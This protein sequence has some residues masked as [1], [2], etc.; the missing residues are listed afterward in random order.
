MSPDP[1]PAALRW[2]AAASAGTC[3]ALV[4]LPFE[5]PVLAIRLG[6]LLVTL[7]EALLGGAVAAA[8]VAAGLARR[9][10]P[11]CPD[12]RLAV[13][14]AA[15]V[16]VLL[17]STLAAP[18]GPLA[19]AKFTLRLA[20]GG[21]FAFAVVWLV[22]TRALAAGRAL[23]AY[24][25]GVGLAAVVGLLE[26][27]LA[28]DLDPVLASF[29]E[30]PQYF[31]E[32]RRLTGTFGSPN[33]AASAM[34]LALPVALVAAARGRGARRVILGAA[35]GVLVL[36]LVLTY[37]RGGVV[38]AAVGLG[39]LAAL[40]AP[41]RG[42]AGER[43]AAVLAALA[44]AAA[45]LALV[46]SDRFA[47]WRVA[48]EGDTTRLTA[49]LGAT[50]G[51]PL[52]AVAGAAGTMRVTVTNTGRVAWRATADAPYRVT[53]AWYD[54]RGVPLGRERV[55]APLPALVAAGETV[56][57]DGRYRV[58]AHAGRAWVAWDLEIGQRLRFSE[59]GSPLAW[60][61]AVVGRDAAEAG[62]LAAEGRPAG[63]PPTR[64]L[65]VTPTRPEMWRAALAMAR[66]RPWLGH[67]PD[68]Y[69]HVYGPY[70]GRVWW[71][72]TIYANN[73]VFELLATTGVLGLVAF[74]AVVLLVAWRGLQAL[75]GAPAGADAPWA[76]AALAMLAAWLAHGLVDYFLAFTAGYVSLFT[77]A[78]VG[79]GLAIS[80]IR[81]SLSR[82]V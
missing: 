63:A 10:E 52:V 39:T 61:A 1:E 33:G 32:A 31:G 7:P 27:W 47:F 80:P 15:F 62:R 81:D 11:V 71:D 67:G 72:Q 57:V 56:T 20:G 64:A 13:A 48:P 69:R 18:A 55:A 73:V 60:V 35:A 2:A 51:E 19:A 49:R 24:A 43:A 74:L 77:L 38:A 76:A 17:A 36:A 42:L 30:R 53:S 40:A 68:S 37:S 29:R 44:L 3:A 14:L 4:A 78:G 70:M 45:W 58:P 21:L 12:L 65:W 75:R 9:R 59:L 54:E 22:R 6:P 28:P 8:A 23:G 26:V 46:P 79:S 50:P 16:T 41:R 5:S 66:E 25:A 82:N 34:A